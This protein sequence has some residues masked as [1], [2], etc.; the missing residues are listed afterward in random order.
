MEKIINNTS[1]KIKQGDITKEKVD[2]IVNAANSHLKMGGGVA[3]A[4]RRAGGEEIQK[5][6][7]KIGYCPL[8]DAVAINAGK[9]DAKYVIHAVGP[10][11]GIDPEPEKNLYNAVYNSLKRAVE[12]NCNSIALPA[13]STGIFGYP[14]DEASEI[15]L[16]A[17][18]DFCEK[19]AQNTLEQ[20]V[21]VLFGDKDFE[22]FKDKFDKMTK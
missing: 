2:A 12:K 6:C 10:R 1:V 7:D 16:R 5:E 22:V 20:I 17:I 14:L 9:L 3:G 18:I 13:I 11:Y 21:V 8:G 15:I 4:I 19:D